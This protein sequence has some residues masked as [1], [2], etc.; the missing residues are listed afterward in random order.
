MIEAGNIKNGNVIEYE[1]SL[2]VVL[3]T[4]VTYVGKKGAYSQI[5]MKNLDDK[6][7]E[8]ER[9]STSD[10]LKKAFLES[11]RMTYL[12]E[13]TAGYVFMDP[14]TGEQT[15]LDRDMMEGLVQYLPYNAE[16]Q[17]EFYEDRAISI[18]LPPNVEL[19]VTDTDPAIKGDTATSVTK[20]A[21]VETG[22]TVKVPGHI[23]Q[24]E[25][26]RVDTRSGEFLGR[27]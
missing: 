20:P 8:T 21:T 22:L 7:I 1:G 27:A 12:Y 4:Q 9:F 5:K 18:E 25:K 3:D 16:V 19:E 23:K 10:K 6:H 15:T 2:W 13:D 11:R 24:G 17:V 26:I 14:D